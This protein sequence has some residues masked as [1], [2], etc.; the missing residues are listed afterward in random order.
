MKV[1]DTYIVGFTHFIARSDVLVSLQVTCVFVYWP[2]LL[3][4][5]TYMVNIL[6]RF[7]TYTA[8]CN[9]DTKLAAIA[10]EMMNYH[11]MQN[12]SQLNF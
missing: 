2:Q 9:K 5:M 8:T 11:D 6:H 1:A 3:F 7:A 10:V 4:V 12:I